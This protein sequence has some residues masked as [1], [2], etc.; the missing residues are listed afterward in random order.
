[1]KSR[2]AAK[3]YAQAL[4]EIALERNE[5]EAAEQ[6]LTDFAKATKNSPLLRQAIENEEMPS[7]RRCAILS[8][9]CAELHSSPLVQEFLKLLVLRNRMTHLGFIATLF[10]DLAAR[11]RECRR[12]QVTLARKDLG[13]DVVK[14]IEEVIGEQLGGNATC[15]L[16]ED[17]AIIGGLL[18]R[19]GDRVVDASV[20]GKL[21]N[22]RDTL[23]R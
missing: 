8:G 19:I 2:L 10:V 22:L 1:V 13:G 15:E 7:M 9:V 6:A 17:P 12:A 21:N 5:I 11:V 16:K 14:R 23:L 4:L 20:R 3:R 18:V